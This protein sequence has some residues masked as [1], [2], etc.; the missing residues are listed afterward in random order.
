MHAHRVRTLAGDDVRG[1]R[2]RAQGLHPE[3][4]AATV[5]QVVAR[6][7][8]VQAQDPRSAALAV[9]PR[10]RGLTALHVDHAKE[11][12]RSIVA[13]WC[14]RGTLHWVS[15]QDVGWMVALL[16][17]RI[18]GASQ[19]RMT[20][21]GLD[22]DKIERSLRL[23]RSTLAT[24]GPLTRAEIA[25]Q[26]VA[27]G[28]KIDPKSQATSSAARGLKGSSVLVLPAMGKMPTSSWTTGL[29]SPVV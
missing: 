3:D 19:R 6:L 23:I 26:L 13:T 8:G 9:R 17:P 7:G 29:A 27:H 15:S 12:E 5:Q 25:A 10:S 4:A 20:E 28:V 24:R 22:E 14:F 18:I 1:L 21:L 11:V 2:F 16:G